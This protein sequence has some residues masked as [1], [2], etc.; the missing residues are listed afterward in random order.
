M[1]N[2]LVDQAFVVWQVFSSQFLKLWADATESAM[3]IPDLLSETELN[4][5]KRRFI[6]KLLQETV[7]FA[8]CCI[9]RRTL[10]I[11][12]VADIRSIKDP[13]VRS[14]LEI[15]N[16]ELSMLLMARHDSV[17][18]IDDVVTLISDFYRAQPNI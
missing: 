3:L 11:A 7:G 12:G 14:K 17:A 1:V 16:L 4:D 8:A 6:R 18:D 5:Y 2:W 15:T 10:G 13:E 9:A